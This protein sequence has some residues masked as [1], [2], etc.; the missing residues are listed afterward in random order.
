MM[1]EGS[2]P[3]CGATPSS[4]QLAAPVLEDR[5]VQMRAAMVLTQ[6]EPTE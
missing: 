6:R 4:D 3:P 2:V 5:H 1:F